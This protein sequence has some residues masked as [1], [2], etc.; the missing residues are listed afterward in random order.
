MLSDL[1]CE[2]WFVSVD[3]LQDGLTQ[4]LVVCTL[5]FRTPSLLLEAGNSTRNGRD[6]LV[7][8]LV[9]TP[10]LL[11]A[12]IGILICLLKGEKRRRGGE[13]GKEGGGGGG[14]RRGERGKGDGSVHMVHP[15]SFWFG[16]HGRFLLPWDDVIAAGGGGGRSLVHRHRMHLYSRFG[17]DGGG[18]RR[19]E[20][21]A[22][23]GVQ[24]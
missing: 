22:G 17:M 18:G 2:E 19:L 24:Q 7:S 1:G 10:N 20:D 11:T 15:E 4:S 16:W 13:G 8:L 23:G 21:A 3:Q 14:S 9:E 5:S 12:H 6:R